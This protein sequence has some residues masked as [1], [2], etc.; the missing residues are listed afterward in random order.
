MS[1]FTILLIAVSL[2]MDAFTLA[3]S[4]GLFNLKISIIIKISIFVGLFHFFMP[5]LGLKVGSFIYEIIPIK[6]DLLMGIIFLILSIDLLINIFKEEEY[7]SINNNIQILLFSFAVSLDSFT[8]GLSLK[9]IDERIL[10]VTTIFMI[11]SSIFT[12][13]GLFFG[14]IIKKIIG[15]KAE[16]FGVVSLIFLAIYYITK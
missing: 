1:F 6:E 7:K 16:L 11:V 13:T 10:L 12:F 4:Y 3:I 8:V 15:K 9:A 14:R 2:S 5:L